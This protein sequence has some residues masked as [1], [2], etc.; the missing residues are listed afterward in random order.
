MISPTAWSEDLVNR[1]WQ[2]FED[3]FSIHCDWTI[4]WGFN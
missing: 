1:N 2:I 3:V 4:L